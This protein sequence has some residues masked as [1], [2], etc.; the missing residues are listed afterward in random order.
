MAGSAYF[1]PGGV[2]NGE[3]PAET[4]GFG[5]SAFGLRASLLLRT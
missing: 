3:P 4:A 1:F 2:V 5:F